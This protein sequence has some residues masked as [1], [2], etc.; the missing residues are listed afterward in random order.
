MKNRTFLVK[1]K[2]M[3]EILLTENAWFDE[4]GNLCVSKHRGSTP[5]LAPTYFKN[6][7]RWRKLPNGHTFPTWCIEEEYEDIFHPNM[8]LRRIAS[9][10]LEPEEA[11]KVA[12]KAVVVK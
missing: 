8:A 11:I 10:K 7:G 6:L 4:H 9:G 12:K 1:F 5:Q 2:T 3:E